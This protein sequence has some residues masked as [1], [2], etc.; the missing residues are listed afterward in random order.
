MTVSSVGSVRKPRLSSRASMMR[1]Y[2]SM[3]W[4]SLNGTSIFAG[5][6]YRFM[7]APHWPR[8][9][10]SGRT[11]SAH[12]PMMLIWRSLLLAH[13]AVN[14]FWS[15]G[16]FGSDFTFGA[17]SATPAFAGDADGSFPVVI[18]L[19]LADA[20]STG[21]PDATSS[22]VPDAWSTGGGCC[23]VIRGSGIR[24][25]QLNRSSFPLAL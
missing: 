18:F 17:A 10:T 14:A 4:A 9:V 20:W 5:R 7:N 22:G 25:P 1:W 8:V 16:S 6:R 23:V 3:I 21:G 12:S 24:I 13:Q 11:V 2:A 19:W 15:I